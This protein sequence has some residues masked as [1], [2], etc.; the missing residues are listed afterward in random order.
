MKNTP[1]YF[2]VLSILA[3]V[4]FLFNACTKDKDPVE[5]KCCTA[6]PPIIE[7][8]LTALQFHYDYDSPGASYGNIRHRFVYNEFNKP[9]VHQEILRVLD[10]THAPARTDTFY[11]NSQ[12]QLIRIKSTDISVSTAGGLYS[13]K[14][15]FFYDA[16][17]RKTSSLKYSLDNTNQYHLSDSTIFVYQD[18]TILKITYH[19]ATSGKDTASFTYNQQKNLVKFTLG[20]F[21]PQ[22]QVLQSYDDKVNPYR[23][24]GL[25][26]FDMDPYP[27]SRWGWDAEFLIMMQAP[28]LPVNN[29][30]YRFSDYDM[31]EYF[32][33]VYYS[34]LD[35]VVAGRSTNHV[36]DVRYSEQYEYT[37]AQ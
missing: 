33:A 2:K 25:E 31:I 9:W 3:G 1:H 6:E 8:L 16:S 26:T 35:S 14:K 5:K 7:W 18:T 20:E 11:Y 13:H 36:E 27:V 15:E 28:R 12:Q 32:Y 21:D 37:P 10:P 34:A 22:M 19:I 17:G 24:S 30:R 4:A 29:Y 23:Y